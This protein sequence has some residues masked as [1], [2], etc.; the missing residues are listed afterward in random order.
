MLPQFQEAPLRRP[1]LS[2]DVLALDAV[3]A[4]AWV[5]A[6]VGGEFAPPVAAELLLAA[7]A[8][9][10]EPEEAGA[11]VVA[12][13]GRAVAVANAVED[14]V[15]TAGGMSVFRDGGDTLVDGL[16]AVLGEWLLEGLRAPVEGAGSGGEYGGGGAVV[17][18]AAD[19]PAGVLPAR[20]CR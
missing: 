7:A 13:A 3:E 10:E 17:A 12:D 16:R 6:V 9:A 5:I 14:G 1:L 8:A 4:P 18:A 2:G 19:W 15:G 11:H 20:T